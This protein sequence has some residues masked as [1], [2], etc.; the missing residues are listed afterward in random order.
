MKKIY[1]TDDNPRNGK[2]KKIRKA[3]IKH[4]KGCNYF[5]IGNRSKAIKEAVLKAEPNEIIL[6]SWKRT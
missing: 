2:S 5:N 6:N 3:I 4:L 1:V